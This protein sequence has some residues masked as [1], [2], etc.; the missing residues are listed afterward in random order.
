MLRNILLIT[1]D[2]ARSRSVGDALLD[3]GTGLFTIER[4]TSRRDSVERL[5]RLRAE[6]FAAIILDLA[7][8]DCQGME[9]F[10]SVFRAAPHIPI[11][12]L[13]REQDE[14]VAKQA[15][16]CGAQDYMLNSRL[17]AQSL[18]QLLNS[19]L[20]RWTFTAALLL[21]GDRARATLNSIGDG[22]V[23]TDAAGNVTYMNSVAEELS[24][25]TLEAANGRPVQDV[26]QI[27][28][29][30]THEPVANPLR[31]A[32]TQD[33]AL[34]LG[35]N[36]VLKHRGGGESAIEDTATPIHNQAG[37]ITGA[38]IVFHD[39]SAARAVSR[40]LS[41]QAQHDFLTDLPN[42][43]LLQDRLTQAIA[44]ARRY[45]KSLAVMFLD[46]DDFKRVNDTLGHD[47]GDQLLQSIAKRLVGCVRGSDTVSRQG[48]DEFVILL[49]EVARA[50][51]VSFSSNKI[52]AAMRKPHTIAG[53]ELKV[54][55]SLGVSVYPYDGADAETLL[56]KADE[57][58]MRAKSRGRTPNVHAVTSTR[59]SA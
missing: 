48:G 25:W 43:L 47:V 44:L 55:V 7:L 50:T 51:D 59:R 18:P 23:S 28:D 26:L 14:D 21:D 8:P 4:A 32:I 31:L 2:A 56:K 5:R 19:V 29:G 58:L 10:E 35:D 6:P 1:A 39:V 57:D 53:Q 33:K 22:V 3:S 52:L 38:V 49:S 41:H 45:R 46:V 17:N 24:G 36:C 54:G 9:T 40:K 34:T 20:E 27:L 13:C 11:L 37:Q 16:R 42:R 30:A 12:I 15:V